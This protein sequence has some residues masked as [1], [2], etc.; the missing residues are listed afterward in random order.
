M[1]ENFKTL[2]LNE[3]DILVM[4]F[5]MLEF[6]ID[7]INDIFQEIKKIIPNNKILAI[8]KGIELSTISIEDIENNKNLISWKVD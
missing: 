6:D 2:Y 8:P 5:D 7:E 1:I 3:N 4:T